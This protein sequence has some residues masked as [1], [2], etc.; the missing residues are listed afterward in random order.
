MK[1][2]TPIALALLAALSFNAH[3]TSPTPV[4]LPETAVVQPIAEVSLQSLTAEQL[5]AGQSRELV[6][7]SKVEVA[8]NAAAEA[9]KQQLENAKPGEV[10][11]IAPG[12]YANLGVIELTADGI[13]VKAEQPGT[14]LLTGLVQ[15]VVKG[16]DITLDSLV[17]TEGGPAERFG[18]VRLEGMRNTLQNSTFYYF[19]DDYEYQPD[20]RRSEYPR[21]L[22]VSLWGKDGKVINNRFEG[23]HKRGTLIGIQKNID[24]QADNHLIE[25]NIFYSQKK[26]R[27]N[28]LAIEKAVRY[29]GNSWEAIRIGDSKS[30]QWPSRTQFVNNLLVDSDGEREL[31]SVKSGENRI[32]GNTIF[33]SASMISLRHG[34]ANVVENNVII[35]NNKQD[36]GGIRIYDEDHVVRNNYLV[37]LRGSGGQIAGNADVRGGVVINTGI[38]DVKNNE[39]LDQEVK[40][41]ELNK[42]WTPKNVTVENNTMVDVEFGMVH[43]NQGHRVSLFDNSQVET[44]FTGDHIRFSSNVVFNLDETLQALRAD[45]ATP[46]TNP[47]YSDEVYYGQVHGVDG[48]PAGVTQQKPTYTKVG[49]FYQFAEGGADVSKLHVLTADEIGPS[50]RLQEAPKR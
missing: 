21:Y 23:K 36:T 38:I 32:A 5:V 49:D 17:F 2:H 33:E 6:D 50:Y 10:I 45:P 46:L 34:K 14:V 29:N 30:S 9:L 22:W 42:Q 24:D 7:A 8:D 3:A 44:I 12:R 16:D 37:G 35:G 48:V 40:G 41:K 1:K 11:T 28:E 31:I 20:E 47:T 26:N 27:Y 25:G 39:Q 43:G 13:T 15:L 18:G 4:Q 19:N